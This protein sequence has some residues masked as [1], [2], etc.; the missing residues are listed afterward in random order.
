METI[1]LDNS[2]DNRKICS[3]A[4]VV[5]GFFDGV[6]IAHQK[7][8]FKARKIADDKQVP[9]VVLTFDK[10]PKELYLDDKKFK[11]IDTLS[12][13]TAK[14][15]KFN[16]DLLVV[17]TFNESTCRLKPADFIDNVILMFNP[18]V[19]V[20][21]YDYTYGPKKIANIQTLLTYSKGKFDLV[22][23]PEATF[24]GVKIGSTE[25]KEAISHGN[26]K[27][28][29]DLLGCPYSMSGVVVHG[30]HRGHMLGFPTANLCI[31]CKKI[32]PCNGVYATQTLIK[33]KLYNSMT[34]VG[35]NDTFNN[36]KKTIET[37][38]FDFCEDIYDEKI[39]LYWYEFIRDNIKFNDINSLIKQLNI[40]KTNIQ[41]YFDKK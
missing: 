13:K 39:I 18:S 5:L 6:H 22:I 4:V 29:A 19:V 12:E 10:H 21:G 31:N 2:I 27:L 7:I 20:V 16:V 24:K 15:R 38:I 32:L 36:N 23:E 26:V 30:F 3:N 41:R 28:A 9:L 33:D 1:L 34:S 17:M 40:D 11:Y 14:M 25:I 37:Y 35:Y 8:I